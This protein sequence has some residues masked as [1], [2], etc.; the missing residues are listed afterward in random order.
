MCR[1][2]ILREQ[3]RPYP[4]A[5]HTWDGIQ[6]ITPEG[7]RFHM[8]DGLKSQFRKMI[9]EGHWQA[10]PHVPAWMLPPQPY[11][12]KSGSMVFWVRP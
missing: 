7:Q 12:K 11:L 2:K 5:D 6:G 1:K 8:S 3:L 10:D 4:V 9:K